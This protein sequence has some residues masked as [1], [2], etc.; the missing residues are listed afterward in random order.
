MLAALARAAGR[1]CTARGHLCMITRCGRPLGPWPP[2]SRPALTTPRCDRPPQLA[3]RARKGQVGEE[4]LRSA[5]LR[6]VERLDPMLAMETSREVRQST[7]TVQDTGLLPWHRA[8]A[9]V[10]GA[11]AGPMP[12]RL[13]CMCLDL[14]PGVAREAQAQ[15]GAGEA[16][17][18]P[19]AVA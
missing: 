7:R 3:K 14:L 1:A 17:S 11:G 10:D 9:E 16:D 19:E 12:L 5:L 8:C 6:A 18:E 15:E 13:P 2:V 4:A